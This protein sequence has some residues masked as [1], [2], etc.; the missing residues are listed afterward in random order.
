MTEIQVSLTPVDL[1]A[2]LSLG[3]GGSVSFFRM[4]NRGAGT[5]YRTVSATS[6][7]PAAIRGFRHPVGSILPVRIVADPAERTWIWNASGTGT[8]VIEDGNY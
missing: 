5:V 1:G 3:T 8:V 7:D 6:P 4:Q 2:A